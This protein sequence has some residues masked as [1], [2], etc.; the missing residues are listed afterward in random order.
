MGGSRLRREGGLPAWTPC[1]CCPATPLL[2]CPW[3]GF[4]ADSVPWAHS[5][6]RPAG[7][8][9]SCISHFLVLSAPMFWRLMFFVSHHPGVTEKAC[10]CAHNNP[11]TAIGADTFSQHHPDLILLAFTCHCPKRYQESSGA[12]QGSQ[13]PGSVPLIQAKKVVTKK[14]REG[15]A[16]PQWSFETQ[17][18]WGNKGT[19]RGEK[20][21]NRVCLDGA[22]N[23]VGILLSRTSYKEMIEHMAKVSY[24]QVGISV[25][26]IWVEN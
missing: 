17:T 24:A 26:F 11:G 8:S 10:P 16:K 22:Q 2:C 13:E 21:G 3:E 14:N 9:L 6:R 1:L 25:L 19:K 12:K 20:V 5:G 18:S 23:H 7:L 15:W 4:P